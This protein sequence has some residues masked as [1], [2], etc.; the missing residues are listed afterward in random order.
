MAGTAD[1]CDKYP[2]AVQ[3]LR[4]PLISFGSVSRCSGRIATVQIEEDNRTLLELFQ[5]PGNNRIVVVDVK[6]E[7]CAVVGDRLASLA[8]ENGWKGI[9]LNGY[10][11]DTRELSQMD[12]CIWALGKCPMRSSL[13]S[14]GAHNIVLS[15]G[16]VNFVP[17][18]YLYADEDGI[19]VSQEK[20]EDIEFLC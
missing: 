14:Q 3:V 4:T 11:R 10:L 7:I 6:G 20:F 1:I 5:T 17:G 8:I 18:G 16:G 15:F 2:H 12:L 13:R 9:I 19:L